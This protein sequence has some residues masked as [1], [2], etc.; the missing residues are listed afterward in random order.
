[1]ATNLV[2]EKIKLLKIKGRHQFNLYKTTFS[3][4]GHFLIGSYV[5]SMQKQLQISN[6]KFGPRAKVYWA[7]VVLGHIISWPK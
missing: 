1:M 3:V 6:W 7:E 4:K 5:R 2:L